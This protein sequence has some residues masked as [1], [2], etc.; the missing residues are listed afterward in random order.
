M[1]AST[2]ARVSRAT[3]RPR[4]FM[5]QRPGTPTTF[6]VIMQQRPLDT[7]LSGK[8]CKWFDTPSFVLGGKDH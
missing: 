6:A 1:N 8:R 4:T 2:R 5:Q 7:G 3:G